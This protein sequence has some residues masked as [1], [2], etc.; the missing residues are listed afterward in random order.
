MNFALI[1]QSVSELTVPNSFH[2]TYLLLEL[3]VV[4][5]VYGSDAKIHLAE[6]FLILPPDFLSQD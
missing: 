1:Y 5:N 6:N 2:T 4:W 3:A